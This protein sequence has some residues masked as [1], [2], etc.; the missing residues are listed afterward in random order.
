L[1][2]RVLIMV[3]LSILPKDPKIGMGDHKSYMI[4]IIL[5]ET[6]IFIMFIQSPVY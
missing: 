2:I 4:L 6:S 3:H 1:M 5:M